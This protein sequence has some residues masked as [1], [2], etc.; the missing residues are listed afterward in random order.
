MKILL[1]AGHGNGDPGAVGNGY[2]EAVLVREIVPILRDKLKAYADVTIFDMGE[3]PY[4]Y[5]KSNSF[6]FKEFD[7]VLEVHFN[8][9]KKETVS[10]GKTMGVEILVHTTEK[11][12]RVENAILS[13]ITALGFTN[14]GVKR[15]SDLRNMNI[16][17]GKQGVSYALIETCF[18][19]DIDDMALY[20][21]KKDEVI[22]GI[23]NGII[24]GFGLKKKETKL[25]SAND[26]IW[27]LTQSIQIDDVNGA[28]AALDKAKKEG[29]PLYWLLYKVVNK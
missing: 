24:K 23:A 9:H 17:K 21:A 19:D 18:I 8:A 22:S 25:T 29:S 12:T 7:Y 10:N 26:I 13:N 6:N 20:N 3:N 14:R 5:L 4:K 11:G 2:Q 15:R 16:C 27:E 28:I 1:M